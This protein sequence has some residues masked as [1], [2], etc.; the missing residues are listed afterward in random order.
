[1][2]GMYDDEDLHANLRLAQAYQK[3]SSFYMQRFCSLDSTVEEACGVISH[4]G[5][6][7]FDRAVGSFSES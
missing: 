1:M 6:E 3:E 4:K 7:A 2:Y 5:E